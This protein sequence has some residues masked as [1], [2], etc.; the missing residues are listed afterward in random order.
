MGR[1]TTYLCPM[2]DVERLKLLIE[3]LDAVAD[4]RHSHKR[5]RCYVFGGEV[6]RFVSPAS[7][8]SDA[9]NLIKELTSN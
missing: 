3:K 7:V 6:L 2:D 4:E 9:E 8:R 1:N 5:Y